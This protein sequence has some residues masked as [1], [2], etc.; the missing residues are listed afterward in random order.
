MMTLNDFY[1]LFFSLHFFYLDFAFSPST[2]HYLEASSLLSATCRP[3]TPLPK[4]VL[5]SPASFSMHFVLR[6]LRAWC[7]GV[8]VILFL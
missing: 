3:F 8:Y 1:P 5:V 6:A 7:P 4:K 2:P